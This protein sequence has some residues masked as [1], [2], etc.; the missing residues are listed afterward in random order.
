MGSSILKVRKFLLISLSPRIEFEVH[1]DPTGVLTL[2]DTCVSGEPFRI[3]FS[4]K[5][6]LQKNVTNVTPT[7]N[8]PPCN[9]K[10]GL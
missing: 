4:I 2:T 7:S 1:F 8:P 9:K 6:S 5:G 3:F 10:A